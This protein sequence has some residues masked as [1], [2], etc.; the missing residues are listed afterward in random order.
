MNNFLKIFSLFLFT[1]FNFCYSQIT[2][3]Y[4]VGDKFGISD[5]NGNIVIKPGFDDIEII[6]NGKFLAFTKYGD[7]FKKSYISNSNVI[8]K[9]TDYDY[10]QEDFG[11]VRAEKQKHEVMF[12][13]SGRLTDVYSLSGK[14]IFDKTFNY[15]VFVEKQ[16][17]P[18]LKKE[19][20]M[21]TKDKKGYFSLVLVNKKTALIVKTFF[22]N[23]I[24]ADTDYEKFP[25]QF[26]VKYVIARESEMRLLTINF[27]DGKIL[28][29]K[30]EILEDGRKNYD[31]ER[32]SRSSMYS[33]AVKI[34]YEE[35]I[36][37]EIPN[38][39]NVIKEAQIHKRY[40]D[41]NTYGKLVFEDKKLTPEYSVM[42]KQNEKWGYFGV[43]S[44]TWIIPPIYDEIFYEN[45]SCVFCEAFVVRTGNKF[46]FLEKE[47]GK[48]DFLSPSFELY[49]HLVRKNFGRDSFYL[50]KLYNADGKFICY[51]DSKGKVYYSK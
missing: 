17:T 34:P 46:Q 50:F 47:N 11:F 4:R 44:N 49:P 7:D 41:P 21:L 6:E 33:D 42:K 31:A 51:G 14:N 35:E 8:L 36:P 18:A 48:N 29:S 30:S 2:V 26:G 19:I 15:V 20:L 40:W 13:E 43:R 22:E 9:D 45:S 38:T 5:E 24:L 3:P 39:V 10:F 32:S 12:G 23:A 27:K 28:T 37:K 1:I 25:T 16:E